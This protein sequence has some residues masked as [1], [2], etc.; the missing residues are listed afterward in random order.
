MHTIT[1]AQTGLRRRIVSSEGWRITQVEQPDG[2]W[3]N[4]TVERETASEATR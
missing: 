1:D 2:S 4:I 3:W